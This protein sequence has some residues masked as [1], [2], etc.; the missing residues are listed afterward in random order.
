MTSVKY[1]LLPCPCCGCRFNE[2]DIHFYTDEGELLGDLEMISDFDHITNPR[3]AIWPEDWDK[4]D[5]ADRDQI[6]KTY[7]SEVEE[8]YTVA[9]LCPFCGFS[10]PFSVGASFLEDERWFQWFVD[11]VNR[12]S[13]RAMEVALQHSVDVLADGPVRRAYQAALSA[14]QAIPGVVKQACEDAEENERY[15]ESR[16][17]WNDD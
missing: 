16:I 13:E 17:D 5:E 1:D 10:K 8:V 12:R 6:V 11:E 2:R 15:M 7:L 14:L 3:N 9:V 4:M